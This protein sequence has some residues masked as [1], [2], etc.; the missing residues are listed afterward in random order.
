MDASVVQRVVPAQPRQ[1]FKASPAIT[2]SSR[3]HANSSIKI[4]PTPSE[5]DTFLL[6]HITNFEVEEP[7]NAAGQHE[8]VLGVWHT[9]E[10]V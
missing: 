7:N 4:S 1:E 6:S 10:G 5:L 2:V 9:H 8:L 3:Q